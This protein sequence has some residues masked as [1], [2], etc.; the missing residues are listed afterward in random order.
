ML[1]LLNLQ[2]TKI[3][4]SPVGKIFM[5]YGQPKTRKTTVASQFP[6]ALIAGFEKGYQFINGAYV[7]NIQKWS[8]FTALV[9]EL[10]KDQVKAKYQTIIIDTIS[11]SY[12]MAYKAVCDRFG[13]DDP[14]QVGYAKAWNAIRDEYQE[15]INTIVRLGYGL[16]L[17]AHADERE[18]IIKKNGKEASDVTIKTDIPR[19][20]H[21]FLSGLADFTLY[22]CKE[23]NDTNANETTVYAYSDLADIETGSRA[24]YMPKRFEFTFTN[25]MSALNNAI[26]MQLKVEN[27]KPTEVVNN[28]HIV[29]EEDFNSLQSRVIRYIGLIAETPAADTMM[30]YFNEHLPNIRVSETTQ[31]HKEK[32]YAAADF[33]LKIGDQLGYDLEDP[34]LVI[35]GP[36]VIVTDAPAT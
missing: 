6:G 35:E 25:L 22:V 2:P 36:T 28:P 14:S 29:R 16:V 19:Q 23:Q 11:I 26:D 34:N 1:D 15:Q 27:V 30:A 17:I 33:L 7:V 24:R 31:I 9:R 8:D 10:K 5:I 12:K 21:S 20:I 3:S 4:S 32:L 13:V 18:N